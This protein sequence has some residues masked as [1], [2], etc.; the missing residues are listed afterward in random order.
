MKNF[1]DGVT[2]IQGFVIDTKGQLSSMKT[3]AGMARIKPYYTMMKG[4]ASETNESCKMF[5]RMAQ[6]MKNDM[7]SIPAEPVD[8]N[9]VDIWLKDILK[10]VS[11]VDFERLRLGQ[12]AVDFDEIVNSFI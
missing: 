7:A 11:F 5:Q 2:G 8:K 6:M 9:Y 3:K 10:S 12:G 1:L 4:I